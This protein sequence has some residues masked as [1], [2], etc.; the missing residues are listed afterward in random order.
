MKCSIRIN[1]WFPNTCLLYERMGREDYGWSVYGVYLQ[2][3]NLH[4]TY[5]YIIIT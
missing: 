1:Y 5:W 2:D 4:A 3:I